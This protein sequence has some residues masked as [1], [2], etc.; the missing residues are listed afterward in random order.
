MSHWVVGGIEQVTC[1]F[2]VIHIFKRY[3][4]DMCTQICFSKLLMPHCLEYI[5][6]RNTVGPRAVQVWNASAWEACS[7]S[8]NAHCALIN[9]CLEVFSLS[10]DQVTDSC[11]QPTSLFL[12]FLC[13][14]R[15]DLFFCGPRPVCVFGE[16]SASQRRGRTLLLS[17]RF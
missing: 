7:V 2:S 16:V 10:N 14:H 13:C 8:G 1:L 3:V 9:T 17:F 15:A 5:Y 6:S 11:S 12:L 4:L